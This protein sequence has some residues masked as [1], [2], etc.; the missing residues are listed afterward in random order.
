MGAFLEQRSL[1]G[2]HGLTADCIP[3]L[4]AFGLKINAVK[5]QPIF[6][7]Y[8]IDPAI[9]CT[10]QMFHRRSIQLRHIPSR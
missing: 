7:D 2:S 6:T 3:R 9:S 1:E 5:S 10:T 4:I 8:P